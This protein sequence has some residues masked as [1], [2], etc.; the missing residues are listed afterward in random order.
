M[1]TLLR[2][3][4]SKL[5]KMNGSCSSFSS[6]NLEDDYEVTEQ[7]LEETTRYTRYMG[8][9]LYNDEKEDD[10]VSVKIISKEG[11]ERGSLRRIVNEVKVLKQ[12]RH[13]N[14]VHVYDVY[15]RKEDIVIVTEY[16]EGIPLHERVVDESFDFTEHDCRYILQTLVNA[17]KYCKEQGVVHRNITPE[18]ILFSTVNGKKIVKIV[19]FQW[20][21]LLEKEAMDFSLLQTMCG[22]PNFVAPEVL[23]GKTYNYK[24]DVWS[25]G[26]ILYLILSGGYLPFS[27]DRDSIAFLLEKIKRGQWDFQPAN[28]WESVSEDAIDLVRQML[29]LK[30][31]ARFS[32]EEILAHKFCTP[33][34]YTKKTMQTYRSTMTSTSSSNCL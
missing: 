12:L 11:L 7:V 15:D 30:P 21:K 14:I 18:N 2:Q 19:G 13:E 6:T 16:L 8:K 26:V 4:L 10:R 31:G 17:L 9:A 27:S 5:K 33:T 25:V 3:A 29:V 24:C 23:K 1:S 28:A 32:Y 22:T 34:I 20:S